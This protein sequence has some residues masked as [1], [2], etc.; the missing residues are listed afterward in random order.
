MCTAFVEGR[1]LRPWINGVPA[2]DYWENDPRI[3]QSGYIGL[4]VHGGGKALVQVKDIRLEVLEGG[5]D[6]PKR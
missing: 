5:A 4:Q 6:L 1:R 2:L 3:A